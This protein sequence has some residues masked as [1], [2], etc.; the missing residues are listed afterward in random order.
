MATFGSG[1]G[2]YGSAYARAVVEG[3][4]PSLLH[5]PSVVLSGACQCEFSVSTSLSF[6][7]GIIFYFLMKAEYTEL[8]LKKQTHARLNLEN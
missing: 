6:G 4:I 5:D 2:T 8:E 3:P 1:G 7:G